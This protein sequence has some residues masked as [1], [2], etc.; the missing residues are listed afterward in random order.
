[1]IFLIFSS[2]LIGIFI[3]W[4]GL[5]I[6]S[7]FLVIYF[8]NKISLNAGIITALTNRLGDAGIIVLLRFY[9]VYGS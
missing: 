9:L 7:Y 2:N 1:M 5:G 4:D 8:Q 6:T 3:G